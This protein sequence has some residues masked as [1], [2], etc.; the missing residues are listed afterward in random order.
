M[1]FIYANA[2][3]VL[4]LD[5]ELQKVSSPGMDDMQINALVSC[6][7]WMTRCWTL[8]EARLAKKYMVALEDEIYLPSRIPTKKSGAS[9]RVDSLKRRV[10]WE[11]GEYIDRTKPLRVDKAGGSWRFA[12]VWKELS[13]W[14]T[15]KPEDLHAILGIML[16]LSP[17]EILRL[18]NKER[19]KAILR[20]KSIYLLPCSTFRDPGQRQTGWVMHGFHCTPPAE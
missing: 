12:N 17:Y 2:E 14:C 5:P 18:D 3:G 8:Q 1:G 20:S 13:E 10:S 4:V 19:M 9:P 7:A 15:T 11:L 6:S 16:N